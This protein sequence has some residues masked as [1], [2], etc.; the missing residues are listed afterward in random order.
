M[1]PLT[2]T[3]CRFWDVWLFMYEICASSGN[4]YKKGTCFRLKGKQTTL[5]KRAEDMVYYSLLITGRVP[6]AAKTRNTSL[7]FSGRGWHA[8][9]GMMWESMSEVLDLL[10]GLCT[11]NLGECIIGFQLW[12]LATCQRISCRCDSHNGSPSST[13]LQKASL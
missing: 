1:K 12:G 3:P 4:L 2:I 11:L 10:C 8:Y 6:L 5:L 7:L 9:I 13:Q